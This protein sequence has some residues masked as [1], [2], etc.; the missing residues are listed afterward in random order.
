MLLNKRTQKQ[1]WWCA[2]V[3]PAPEVEE[4]WELEVFSDCIAIF[5]SR[6]S[7]GAGATFVNMWV[8]TPS[9]VKGPFTGATHQIACISDIYIMFHIIAKLQL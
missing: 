9:K 1:A 2:F 6:V 4:R 7:K 3:T 5:G 8:V